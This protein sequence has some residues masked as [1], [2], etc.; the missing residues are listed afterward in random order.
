M[1]DYRPPGGGEVY[2][3]KGAA[4]RGPLAIQSTQAGPGYWLVP[5]DTGMGDTVLKDTVLMDTGLK[6]TVLEDTDITTC[7][8]SV[9][10]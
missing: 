1:V 5:V 6:D 3:T 2:R 10:I 8:D 7:L 4:G 9:G